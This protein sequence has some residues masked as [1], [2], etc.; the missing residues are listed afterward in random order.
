MIELMI[1][2]VLLSLFLAGVATVF[3]ANQN[4]FA[5]G[6]DKVVLQQNVTWASEYITRTLR[7]ARTVTIAG[8]NSDLSAYDFEGNLICR[9]YRD[10]GASK[11]MF[12]VAGQPARE[13]LPE[14]V[15]SLAFTPNGD[16]T[17]VQYVFEAEDRNYNK[18]V[19]RSSAKL[20]NH[21]DTSKRSYM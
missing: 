2:I 20:R 1:S 9:Y 8:G 4:A 16:T 21:W 11:L 10:S 3:L 7:Y 12:E 13:L 5:R 19:I 14:K 18:V 15:N 6:R 17:R